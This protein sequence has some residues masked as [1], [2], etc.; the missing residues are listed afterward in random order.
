[1]KKIIL[2][3][4]LVLVLCLTS[5]AGGKTV[6]LTESNFNE[7]FIVNSYVENQNTE[8]VLF[9][10]ETTC[11]WTIEIIPINNLEAKNVKLKLKLGSYPEW[12]A[13]EIYTENDASYI[14]IVIPSNGT[15][16]KIVQCTSY[17]LTSGGS[18]DL[19]CSIS[20]VEGSVV[21]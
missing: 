3:F 18:H 10:Y 13:A 19:N 7:Y 4:Q 16:K 9:G 5:C 20:D 14:D 12:E 8:S 15:V 1:M 6:E 17:S 21:V 11:N 2:A